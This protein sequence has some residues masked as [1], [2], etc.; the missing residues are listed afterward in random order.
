MTE[1][2]VLQ[3]IEA[4]LKRSMGA[5]QDPQPRASRVTRPSQSKKN[6]ELKGF[7]DQVMKATTSLTTLT[8]QTD[9][10][11]N[12]T[13]RARGEMVGF[14][15][16]IRSTGLVFTALADSIAKV[17]GTMGLSDAQVTAGIRTAKEVDDGLADVAQ[18]A[19]RVEHEFHV[20]SGKSILL[21]NAFTSLTQQITGSGATITAAT[22]THTEKLGDAGDLAV[23]QS[24]E[25]A[26][27][28]KKETN[29]LQRAFNRLGVSTEKAIPAA[30]WLQGQL[31]LMI[32]PL[33]TAFVDVIRDIYHLQAQGISAAGSMGELYGNAI[34]AGMSLQDYTSMLQDNSAAVMRA[35]S[36]S[37][38]GDSVDRT[39]NQLTRLG[40]FG[41]SGEKLAASLRANAVSVGV[42][43]AQQE[44][45]VNSQVKLFA[46]LRASTLMTADAF[47]DLVADI[48]N[49]QNVQE[50]LLGLAPAERDA[51]LAQIQQGATIG[52]RLGATAEAS[53]RLTDALLAQRGATAEQR[54]QAA[55]LIRQAGAITGMNSADTEEFARLRLKKNRTADENVRFA[56][57]SGELEQRLQQ[58]QNSGNIQ[59][60]FIADKLGELIGSTPQGE[61]QKAA[62]LVKQQTEAGGIA[63]K[64]ANKETSTALQ[65]VG[66]AL[67]VLTGLYKNPI[68]EASVELGKLL[69]ATGLQVFFL[70]RI[71]DNTDPNKVVR[72]TVSTNG[73][74][75]KGGKGGR[76][77]ILSR[78]LGLG[79]LSDIALDISDGDMMGGVGG[80]KGEILP[81]AAKKGM[82]S[83]MFSGLKG[84]LGGMVRGFPLA[85]LIFGAVEE[86]FTGEMAA[87]LGFGDGL[88]G[89]LMGAVTASLNG[90]FTGITRLFD[91]GLNAVMEGLGINFTFNITK[92]FDYMTMVVVELFQGIALRAEYGW[93]ALKSG[94]FGFFSTV[95][96]AIPGISSDAPWVKGLRESAEEAGK[97]AELLDKQL[98]EHYEKGAKTR[99][100]FWAKEG[101]TLR[102]EGAARLKMQ[103]DTAA[104]SKQLI[105]TTEKN[106]VYGLENLAASAKRTL[107]GSESMATPSGQT[108]TMIA[109]PQ[110]TAQPSVTSTSVNTASKAEDAKKDSPDK[111][112]ALTVLGMQELLATAQ[113]QLDVLKQ[114]LATS[115]KQG[116]ESIPVLRPRF[117]DNARTLGLLSDIQAA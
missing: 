53:K 15:T 7:T 28:T 102:S 24:R 25:D 46:T 68:G 96:D 23:R 79:G 62:G 105:A 42:G 113:Q 88:G 45:A 47:K 71:A 89:R 109:T 111:I 5:A 86:M 92:V 4:L 12:S 84:M 82:M 27:E 26:K 85:S 38:F 55:G 8:R 116:E 64:D 22:T 100:E 93:N 44:K 52:Y 16:D 74:G 29:F 90:L 115:E 43:Q 14:R 78:M 106:V 80:N 56:A 95:L 37:E 117:S 58:M 17:S 57:L 104:K 39:T 65:Q 60:E 112:Q 76:G 94:I 33:K 36:M 72:G 73:G 20:L 77:G 40:V 18:A 114:M 34:K 30:G 59:A 110:P 98:T 87:A 50:E 97:H 9:R 49:N 81:E 41:P 21:G 19:E 99:A 35:G 61:V 2:Q 51:R 66:E 48:T 107:A 13:Y 10:L 63:N 54:F 1:L 83:R 11:S 69:V 70:K 91:A 31:A 6:P 101:N 67:T 3:N 32:D 103:E 75:K 108:T